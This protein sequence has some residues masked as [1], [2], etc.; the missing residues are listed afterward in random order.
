MAQ[1]SPKG[2]AETGAGCLLSLMLSGGV[3]FF[4][5]RFLGL[6]VAGLMSVF[7]VLPIVTIF[8]M[9]W[10]SNLAKP[11]NEDEERRKQAHE[12]VVFMN[13][14]LEKGRL[15]RKVDRAPGLLLEECARHWGR[16]HDALSGAFWED[17]ELPLHWKTIR[18][19]SLAA[20]DRAMDD[21]VVM[22]KPV[23]EPRNPRTGPEEFIGDVL[24]SFFNIST[25]APFEPLP[26]AFLPARDIAQK[27]KALADEVEVASAKA[28]R[29]QAF[30]EHY[31]SPTQIDEV[32][33]NLREIRQA[34][35]EL[36]QEV[37]RPPTE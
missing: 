31:S 36:H 24:E 3:W 4:L 13:G 21:I 15:H 20:A 18:E 2:T 8:T 30:T 33:M 14:A 34:E 12:A 5:E 32:L 1:R 16:V 25:E 26:A 29:D 10:V 23:L 28:V 37:G 6:W 27:L 9:L 22:L 17:K 11:K 35:T 19:S 7:V